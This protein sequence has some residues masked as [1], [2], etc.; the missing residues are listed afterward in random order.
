MKSIHDK[1]PASKVCTICGGEKREYSDRC[2]ACRLKSPRAYCWAVGSAVHIS[3]PC[4]ECGSPKGHEPIEDQNKCG[5]FARCLV[6]DV[7]NFTGQKEH[8]HSCSL[9]YNHEG[10]HKCDEAFVECMQEHL[11]FVDSTERLAKADENG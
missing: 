8:G 5:D 10:N 6:G 11:A 9:D 7:E 2:E 4:G 1:K 3:L